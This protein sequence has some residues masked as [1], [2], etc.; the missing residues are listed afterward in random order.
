M[1]IWRK[2]GA[3]AGAYGLL[4]RYLDRRG[5]RRYRG[6]RGYRRRGLLRRLLG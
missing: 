5:R 6:Y 4:R 1:G 2:A 3:W